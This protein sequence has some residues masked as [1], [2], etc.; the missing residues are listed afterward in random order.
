MLIW[1]R[2]NFFLRNMLG[3]YFIVYVCYLPFI[4]NNLCTNYALTNWNTCTGLL[5]FQVVKVCIRCNNKRQGLGVGIYHICEDPRRTP[6]YQSLRL[7]FG[8]LEWIDT[9]FFL[10][11]KNKRLN[12]FRKTP[13]INTHVPKNWRGIHITI[14]TTTKYDSLHF[15]RKLIEIHS[16]L[17]TDR[18]EIYTIKF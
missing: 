16:C 18:T 8:E 4:I 2:Y 5:L 14:I 12:N 17:E 11:S 1:P 13:Y 6:L 15:L 10:R 3:N 7:N 9:F